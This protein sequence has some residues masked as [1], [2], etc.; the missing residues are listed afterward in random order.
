MTK[1]L[2]IFGAVLLIVCAF[3]LL[4][5]KD[6]EAAD[7]AG[8]DLSQYLSAEKN[9]ISVAFCVDFERIVKTGLLDKYVVF[10]DEIM[11][12]SKPEE[13]AKFDQG[14]A[15]IKMQMD[16]F[17]FDFKRD[18]KKV[19]VKFEGNPE[20]DH[21]EILI[22]INANFSKEKLEGIVTG[23]MGQSLL[24]EN[25]RNEKIFYTND[26]FAFTFIDNKVIALSVSKDQVKGAIDSYYKKTSSGKPTGRLD[27]MYRRLGSGKISWGYVYLPES[28]IN[29]IKQTDEMTKYFS[30]LFDIDLLFIS[31]DFDGKYYEEEMNIF[32]KNPKSGQLL[33]DAVMGAK[34]IGKLFLAA[35]PE[36]M[37]ML[38]NLKVNQNSKNNSISVS[39]KFDLEKTMAFMK[40][41]VIKAIEKQ[42]LEQLEESVNPETPESAPVQPESPQK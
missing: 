31:T 41:F 6:A 18:L 3:F 21:Y 7:L 37:E 4:T 20:Q 26:N 1:K 5:Q 14:W 38:N 11:A 25:F 13:K 27:D 33:A 42:R 40:E 22:L 36:L 29:K 34:S 28:I 9:N 17:G 19:F 32:L 15:M 23:M 12:S 39:F 2:L 10:F 30:V 24:S 8:I 35:E 16:S